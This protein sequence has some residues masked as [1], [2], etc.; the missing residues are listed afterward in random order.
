[1]WG[2]DSPSRSR[3]RVH[4]TSGKGTPSGWFSALASFEVD[5]PAAVSYGDPQSNGLVE[6]PDP[7]MMSD[8][9]ERP[10]RWPPEG[11]PLEPT[12]RPSHPPRTLAVCEDENNLRSIRCNALR[13]PLASRPKDLHR[14]RAHH[15][16]PVHPELPSGEPLVRRKPTPQPTSSPLLEE[17]HSHVMDRSWCAISYGHRRGGFAFLVSGPI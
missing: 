15:W 3:R 14:V 17:D 13:L 9:T 12:V 7:R 1:L 2:S 10:A 5:G 11:T 6:D 4:L 16:H 8:L